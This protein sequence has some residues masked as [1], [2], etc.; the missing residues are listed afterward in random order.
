M[1]HNTIFVCICVLICFFI[2]VIF[3]ALYRTFHTFK[4]GE[5][6]EASISEF[7]IEPSNETI[8]DGC[9]I[10]KQKNDC[11]LIYVPP[12]SMWSGIWTI[13]PSDTKF[14]SHDASIVDYTDLRLGMMLR[15][16]PHDEFIQSI[17][18]TPLHDVEY[19]ETWGSY[20]AELYEAGINYYNNRIPS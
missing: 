11:L 20:N 12:A 17:F 2:I 6:G 7:E 18:P 14:I 10:I 19:I 1:R 9:I 3:G 13:D 5:L 15:F 16:L 4:N 8:V